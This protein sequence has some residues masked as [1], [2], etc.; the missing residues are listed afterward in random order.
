M[1]SLPNFRAIVPADVVEAP[2]AIAEAAR[3]VPSRKGSQR[4]EAQRRLPV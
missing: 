4:D 2:R 1:L 3:E